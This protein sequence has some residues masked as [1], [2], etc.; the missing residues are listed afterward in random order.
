MPRLRRGAASWFAAPDGDPVVPRV[1]TTQNR[2]PGILS[3]KLYP[4]DPKIY[5][6]ADDDDDDVNTRRALQSIPRDYAATFNCW[7]SRWF[8]SFPTMYMHLI[9]SSRLLRNN[10]ILRKSLRG[11]KSRDDLI[12]IYSPSLRRS[13]SVYLPLGLGRAGRKESRKISPCSH[14]AN[15][16]HSLVSRGWCVRI[17]WTCVLAVYSVV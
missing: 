6:R 13:V 8:W 2:R 4:R 3:M 15:I 5:S 9:S 7:R 17:R 10:N 14:C 11:E 1:G 16:F 12:T